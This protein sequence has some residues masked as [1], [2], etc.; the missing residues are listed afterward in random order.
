MQR[1]QELMRRLLAPIVTKFDELLRYM[2]AEPDLERQA[3]CAKCINQAMGFA[4]YVDLVYIEISVFLTGSTP[5]GESTVVSI[6]SCRCT[7][8]CPEPVHGKKN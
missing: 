2:M 1:K 3:G 7:Y 6:V 4:R 8:C 5:C